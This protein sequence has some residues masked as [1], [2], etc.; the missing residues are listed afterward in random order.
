MAVTNAESVYGNWVPGKFVYVP[1]ILSAALI[2]LALIWPLSVAFAVPFVVAGV[3]FA[4]ARRALSPGG[5]D[6]QTKLWKLLLERLDWD[7]EG[8]ALDIGCGSGPLVVAMAEQ[9]T[10]ARVTG[11]DCWGE[12]W[13][14]SQEAC[15]RNAQAAGVA[16]R[17]D[18]RKAGASALPFEDGAFDAVVSNNVFHEVADTRDKRELIKEALRVLRKGGRFAFQDLFLWKAVYGG[19]GDLLQ[20]IRDCGLAE[21][22]FVDTSASDFIPTALKLPFMVGCIGIIYGTK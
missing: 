11:I 9:H 15:E 22:D 19:I 21:V 18:F 10:Q 7:G 16:G 20:A 12:R 1:L 14:Y 2:G 4:W 3:Y 8:R 5:R 13:D 17:T 6:I